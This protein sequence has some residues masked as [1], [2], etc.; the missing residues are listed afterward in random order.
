M[1]FYSS[2]LLNK[3]AIM[4]IMLNLT[5][6][7]NLKLIQCQFILPIMFLHEI[8]GTYVEPD[9]RSKQN[10]K[11]RSIAFYLNVKLYKIKE[12]S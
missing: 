5:E 4:Q 9:D 2:V 8:T 12:S 7:K 6:E 3:N 11:C 10:Q 1:S